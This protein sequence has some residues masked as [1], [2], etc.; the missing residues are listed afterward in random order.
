M[1][2]RWARR[3]RPFYARERAVL[4]SA[5]SMEDLDA[6]MRERM[7]MLGSMGGKKRRQQRRQTAGEI[8]AQAGAAAGGEPCGAREVE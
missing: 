4:A 1:S 7:R 3:K 6:R 5:L 8:D 2:S